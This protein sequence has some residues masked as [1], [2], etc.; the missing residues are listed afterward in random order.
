[1]TRDASA[2]FRYGD[3]VSIEKPLE[4]LV[5]GD[6]LYFGSDKDGKKNITH[7]GMYTGDTEFIHATAG[8]GMV[9][10]NS[11]DST[12]TNYSAY[13]LEILQGARRVTTFTEGKGLERVSQ[14][15]W[16]F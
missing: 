12:R 16:Y 6:L 8:P 15:S 3:E 7:T 10:V 14:H 1:M 11:F 2:Q 5:P 13:L 9:I 4:S